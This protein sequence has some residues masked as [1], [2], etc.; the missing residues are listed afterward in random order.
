MSA[1]V[2][3]A[4]EW[5]YRGVWSIV[6]GWFR[7][8]GG[9]PRPPARAGDVVEVFHPAPGYLR[10]LK[11]LFWL[12]LFALDICI[13]VP[14]LILCF[15][16]PWIG[17]LIAIPVL[18]AAFVP[19]I[20]AYLALHLRVDTMWYGLTDRS[21]FIR[22]G[23][24]IIHETTITYENIQNATVRQGPLQRYFGISTL[25]VRTAGGG[26]PG[27]HGG[28]RPGGHIGLLE[29]IAD[30][31]RLRDLIMDRARRSKSAG[32]G[33]EREAQ[34]HATGAGWAPEHVAVLREI[35]DRARRLGPATSRP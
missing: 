9:P 35:L 19:D 13:I 33:D 18:A 8:P 6:V 28:A 27:P 16:M 23:I 14:W 32:L 3:R 30:A 12:G 20:I 2:E 15:V 17:A 1:R 31:A 5:I 22:R 24:W 11:F 7:V 29:G 26:T 4:A 25:E 10:Y 21:L 34:A